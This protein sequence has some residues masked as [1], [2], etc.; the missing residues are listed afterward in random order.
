M[1]TV[2][3]DLSVN[4]N[5]CLSRDLLSYRIAEGHIM[6]TIL[7]MKVILHSAAEFF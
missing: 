6:Y 2:S 3:M 1:L 4:L 7:L 5:I